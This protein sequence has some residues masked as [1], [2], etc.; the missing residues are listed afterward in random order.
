M[1][2]VTFD[3]HSGREDCF[4][5]LGFAKTEVVQRWSG[6]FPE[7]SRWRMSLAR[8]LPALEKKALLIAKEVTWDPGGKLM[9][10]QDV[11]MIRGGAL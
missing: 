3:R 8:R 11:V 1:E 4:S 9:N 6:R 10:G 7:T 2:L 5:E